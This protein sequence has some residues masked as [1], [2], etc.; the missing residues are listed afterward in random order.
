MAYDTYISI[1]SCFV[2]VFYSIPARQKHTGM[3][4]LGLTCSAGV[5]DLDIWS[6]IK[7]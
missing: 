6:N 5:H 1:T 3:F 7:N 4:C 2:L